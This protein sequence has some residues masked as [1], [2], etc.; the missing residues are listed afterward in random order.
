[1]DERQI[2]QRIL[3]LQ[4]IV[5]LAFFALTAKL[6]HI[7]IIQGA[8]YLLQSRQN[9]IAVSDLDAPRG[10]IYDRNG[11]ILVRNRPYFSATLQSALVLNETWLLWEEEEWQQVA[12]TLKRI[13]DILQMPFP[14][15]QPA[16]G[17]RTAFDEASGSL[18]IENIEKLCQ[19]GRLLECFAEALVTAPYDD[20]ALQKDIEATMAF[21]VMENSIN[22]P[23]VDIVAKSQ[24]QYVDG[25][26]FAHLIG[27][28]LP[29]TQRQ[30]DRQTIYTT[31]PYLSSDRIGMAGVEAGFEEILRGVRGQRQVEQN[32]VGRQIRLLDEEPAMPGNN[33]FLTIDA[34]LQQAVTEALQTGMDEVNSK[35]GVAIVMN[36]NTGEVLAMVSLPSYDNNIFVGD[37]DPED[38]QKLFDDPLKPI[39]NRAISGNYP[40]GSIF[41]IIPAAAGLAE[42]T[43]TPNTAIY[44]P[45]KIAIGAQEF[46]CWL[47]EGHRDQNVIQ[48]IA[49]SCDVFFYE[50]VGGY[51]EQFHGMGIDALSKWSSEFGLGEPTRIKLPGEGAGRVPT[52]QW[53]RLTHQE[54]WLIGDSYNMS[55]GQ[56]FLLVTPLQ[57]LNATAAIANGGTIYEPQ[58][59]VQAQNSNGEVI[60]AFEPKVLRQINMSK[61]DIATVAEGMRGTIEMDDGTAW[62]RFRGAPVNVAGKT[63][64]A[65][66]CPVIKKEDGG[67]DCLRDEEGYQLTHAW[68]T[69]FAPYEKPEIAIVVF[70][71]G[72][73]ESVIQGSEVAAP[74]ARRIIEHYFASPPLEAVD[75]EE[76]QQLSLP[77]AD[78]PH[79]VGK[80]LRW[81]SQGTS[82]NYILGQVLDKA[83]TAVAEVLITIYADGKAIGS[84]I[85]EAD[86][87]FRVNQL[88]PKGVTTWTIRAPLL[89]GNPKLEIEAEPQQLYEVLFKAELEPINPQPEQ[90]ETE[91]P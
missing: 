35:E 91:Q 39:F 11:H 65:E 4:L 10:V 44:D 66:Y 57:I 2:S 22:L 13:A 60:R 77:T 6:W 83:G 37:I 46:V 51:L 5:I 45:G 84:V 19:E 36:P 67:Y 25:P 53:K 23:G 90:E 71:H 75:V 29:I 88:D 58:I 21:M 52:R 78:K 17:L 30:L 24:R 80:L 72:N 70:V 87:R 76:P 62:W 7:Q 8:D 31:N 63:G 33:L 43:I 59:V 74:I 86:G 48:A 81:E 9:K 85:S 32:V 14:S 28:N 20:I 3:F 16:E 79:Y 69:A 47:E 42:G 89:A 68:F 49:H 40:P 50:V 54:S 27:Y 34:G 56:G 1:M 26:L 38:Y 64:T 18:L 55:I 82:Q 15:E 61:E 41:K 73:N 12:D